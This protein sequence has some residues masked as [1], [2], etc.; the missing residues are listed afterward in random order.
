VLKGHH[1]GLSR[2]RLIEYVH[3][4]N[5]SGEIKCAQIRLDSSPWRLNFGELRLLF[6]GHHYICFTS[7]FW[8]LDLW[9]GF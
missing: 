1:K 3:L 2:E 9:R 8:G 4:V 6:V 7:F 5:K